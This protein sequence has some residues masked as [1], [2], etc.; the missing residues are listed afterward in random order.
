MPL[1]ENSPQNHQN[2]D[3]AG[4]YKLLA[5]L[6]S[7][8]IDPG[9]RIAIELFITGYGRSSGCKIFSAFSEAI[10]DEAD[11][12]IK[13]GVTLE[14]E[15]LKLGTIEHK[16]SEET[17]KLTRC[18]ILGGV[19][20]GNWI[21]STQFFDTDNDSNTIFT[22][23]REPNPPITYDLRIS[24]KTKPGLH[25]ANFTLTYY[26]GSCWE[27]H[28]ITVNF[29]VRNFFERHAG[30]LSAIGAAAAIFSAIS[31]S[32]TIYKNIYGVAPLQTTQHSK[33]VSCKSN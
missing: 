1:K 17:G 11:S 8:V 14:D 2:H 18:I 7:D 23:T 31:S 10:I 5:V 22:E 20:Y 32:T 33:Q 26:N 13:S 30:K 29:K 27:C 4:C 16:I 21:E 9:E 3:K 12:V 19:K 6:S 28:S 24:K 15:K 25:S